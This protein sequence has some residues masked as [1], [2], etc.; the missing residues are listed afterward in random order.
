MPAS[1]VVESISLQHDMIREGGSMHLTEKAIER[2]IQGDLP[3]EERK[4]AVRH[5][6]T[7]CPECVRLAQTV[8]ARRFRR[9]RPGRAGVEIYDRIFKR[10]EG[11]V[12]SLQEKFYRERL[13]AS[14]Q[15]ASLEKLAQAQ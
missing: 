12:S 15:W 5:L 13:L 14:G 7:R 2:L 4:A 9:G 10:V 6:L 1:L 11:A 3:R 8:A